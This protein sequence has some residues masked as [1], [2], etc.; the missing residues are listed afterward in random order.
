MKKFLT[1]FL[2]LVLMMSLFAPIAAADNGSGAPSREDMRGHG[3]IAVP[4]KDSWL[5]AYETRYVCASG[6]VAA[7]LFT[8]P[9][10]DMDLH[11]DDVLEGTELTLLAKQ[12]DRNG[13]EFYL[14]KM[15]DRRLAWICAGQTA[16]DTKLLDSVPDLT[17]GSWILN[18]GEGEKNSFAVQF[19]PKRSAT[20]R[21]VS[22]GA[23][24]GS[25]W[26]L[27]GRR[28]WV[29]EKYFI[30]DGE[31]FVSRDE[32]QTGQ[33]KIRFTLTRDTEGVYDKLSEAKK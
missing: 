7:F 3:D 11:F 2:A 18:K 33:G 9:V 24:I 30:W 8:A 27:S 15:A 16:E 32:F 5:P 28:V 12:S 23:R 20:L 19:G 17:E 22:D 10:L 21:R 29:D 4:R 14:V 1:I 13:C 25:G 31:Q 6:G 26:I